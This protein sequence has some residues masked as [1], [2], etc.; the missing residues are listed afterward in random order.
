MYRVIMGT[1]IT[2]HNLKHDD[3]VDALAYQ[4]ILIDKMSEGYTPDE[5]KQEEY[6]SEY[7]SSGWNDVGRDSMTGY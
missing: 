6:D 7:E 5:I 4:G 1:I 2:Q 3:T